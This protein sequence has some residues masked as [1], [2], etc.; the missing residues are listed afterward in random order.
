V[1]AAGAFLPSLWAGFVADDF[2]LLRTV[3]RYGGLFW[4]LTR[5]DRGQSGDAGH[6]Y[7][8]FWVAWNGSIY[9]LVGAHAFVFHAGNLSLFVVATLEVWVLARRLLPAHAA[10]VAA[11]GFAVYPRH[12]ETVSWIS[13]NTDLAAAVPALAAVLVAL[14]PG[15]PVAR[16]LAAGAL[17]GI[18]AASKEVAFAV[19]ALLV[20]C[21]AT[22]PTDE[23]RRLSR[24][25]GVAVGAMVVADAAVLVARVVVIG[26][27]GGYGNYGFGPEHV[28]GTATTY[29]VAALTPPTV[30]LFRYPELLALPLVAVA[31]T[32]WAAR[33]RPE[34]RRVA[35]AGVAWFVLAALPSLSLAIDLNSGNGERLLF[36]PS[37]GL[38]LSFGALAPRRGIAVAAAAVA[39]LGL[40]LYSAWNW[41]PAGRL[42]RDV[43][44]ETAAIGP[45]DGEVV[46]LSVPATYRNAQVFPGGEL[47]AALAYYG[48][49]DLASAFCAPVQLRHRGAGEV[50]FARTGG[51]YVGRA[52]WSAAFDVPVLHR[53]EPL[54]GDCFY[55][56]EHPDGWPPGLTRSVAVTPRPSRPHAV[57]VY[58]DGDRL[59][60]VQS[61]RAA[62]TP[63]G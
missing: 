46:L 4:A 40:C 42:A 7:R 63:H 1:L 53:I 60:P 9:D 28:A 44:R 15:R 26:G 31:V 8:P 56:R 24:P 22:L 33:R 25:V 41:V 13:G 29:V 16:A 43:A 45:R 39:A 21:W 62:G 18:A 54:G 6:F 10:F 48:R 49:D 58:F 47:N 11:A 51:G 36:L 30:Q 34:S 3:R 55:A 35:L 38:A 52:S 32:V 19:P 57:L 27:S 17:A 61:A 20:V 23:R 2:V 59:R 37:A 14:A 5:N 12:G 50:V